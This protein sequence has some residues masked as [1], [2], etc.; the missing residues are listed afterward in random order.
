VRYRAGEIPRS[1]NGCIPGSAA[2]T[3]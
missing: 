1:Q 3:D 2:A